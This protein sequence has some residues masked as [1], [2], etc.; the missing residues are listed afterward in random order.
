MNNLQR[1]LND[2]FR[3]TL[4]DER[5]IN[6][7]RSPVKFY[8]CIRHLEHCARRENVPFARVKHRCKEKLERP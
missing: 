1:R 4:S 7:A 2:R 6:V 5:T 3:V 8:H